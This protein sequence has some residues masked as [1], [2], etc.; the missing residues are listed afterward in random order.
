MALPLAHLVLSAADHGFQFCYFYALLP[1]LNLCLSFHS[2]QKSLWLGKPQLHKTKFNAYHM[3]QHRCLRPWA[4]LS[5]PT[6]GSTSWADASQT[7]PGMTEQGMWKKQIL[8]AT[9]ILEPWKHSHNLLVLVDVDTLHGVHSP[10]FARKL[11][12]ASQMVW[13]PPQKWANSE[14]GKSISNN[15]LK[16]QSSVALSVNYY[17]SKF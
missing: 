12:A 3:T 8:K 16:K 2:R 9:E 7:T 11:P 6:Q 10:S 4:S 17:I 13:T 1:P 14:L 5:A 15:P